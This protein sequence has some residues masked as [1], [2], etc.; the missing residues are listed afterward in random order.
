MMQSKYPKN[1]GFIPLSRA[2]PTSRAELTQQAKH[3]E[4]QGN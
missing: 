1:N 4:K 3:K 2:K